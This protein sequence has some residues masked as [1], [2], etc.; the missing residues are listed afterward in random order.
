[1][2]LA[3]PDLYLRGVADPADVV[4]RV[5]AALRAEADVERRQ[6][7][8]AVLRDVSPV[9]PSVGRH[10]A[11]PPPGEWVQSPAELPA[12]VPAQRTPDASDALH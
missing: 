6:W 5:R 8:R 2:A 9:S 1:M 10:P 3:L 12:A 7:I 4:M 11:S